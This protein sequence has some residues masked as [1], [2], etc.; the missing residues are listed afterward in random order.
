M[1]YKDITMVSQLT[2]DRINLL[3]V[4]ASHWTGPMSV[5][6]YVERK[7]LPE[8]GSV[9]SLMDPVLQRSNIDLH[10]VLKE[11]VG[12]LTYFFKHHQTL[13]FFHKQKDKE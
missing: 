12:I 11:G 7:H 6:V 2:L 3:N 13:I 5:T 9:L 10:I 8:L 4:H 1:D